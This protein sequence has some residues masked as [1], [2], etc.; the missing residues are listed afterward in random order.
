MQNKTLT[1]I[2]PNQTPGMGPLSV[3]RPRHWQVDGNL[4]TLTTMDD[5]G[6]PASVSRWR[7]VP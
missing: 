4:L 3:N 5:E 2:V 1:Y 6:K 7:K